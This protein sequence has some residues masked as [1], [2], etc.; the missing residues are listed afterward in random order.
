MRPFDTAICL[1]SVAQ[2]E[3]LSSAAADSRILSCLLC[4]R[5]LS[6]ER[7]EAA[8]AKGLPPPPTLHVVAENQEDQTASLA[9][10]P[11]TFGSGHEPDFVN[12][13]AIIARSLAINLAYPE[14]QDAIS[15]LLV[16]R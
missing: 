2:D 13:Q 3:D 14:I 6:A 1:G 9:V 4:L 15:E 7:A 16:S 5:K 10:V 8:V 12:T 11:R